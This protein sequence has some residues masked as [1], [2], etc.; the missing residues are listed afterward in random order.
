MIKGAD[1]GSAIVVWDREDYIKKA[2]NQL[3]DS[4]IYEEVPNDAKSLRNIILN[5]LENIHKRGDVCTDTLNYF[6]MKDA[7]FARFYLLPKIHKRLY[8][9]P[10]I[11]NCGY[12]TENISSFLDFHLQPI[13][14][15]V[16]SYINDT[17]DFLKKLCSL[18]N[19]PSNSLLC[20]MD[21]VGL[22]PNIPPDEGLSALR[23]RLNESDKKDV[24]TD[25][26]VEFAELVLKNNIF[27]FNK[28]TL[29]QKRGT[30]IGTKFAPPYSILFMA[31]LEEKILEIVDNK[32][33]IWWRY[34][35]DIFFIWEHGEEK[36]RDFVQTL[37]EIHPTIK[38]T[39]EWS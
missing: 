22:Y 9:V 28:R 16:K 13:A 34:I 32:P 33:Y 26:L 4:N 38:F 8:N 10:V 15:K 29:K 3:G 7:K 19:L 21:V 20:T 1:K 18:T 27:N 37:S 12:Y 30:A 5:T 25:T 17:N 24:S 39:A 36:F 2:E 31:E 14:K 11:S 23:K 35:D 6:L